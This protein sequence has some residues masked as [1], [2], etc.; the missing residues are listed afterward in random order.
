MYLSFFFTPKHFFIRKLSKVA[1]EYLFYVDLLFKTVFT[2]ILKTWMK[3][4]KKPLA[5]LNEKKTI[6]VFWYLLLNLLPN[7]FFHRPTKHFPIHKKLIVFRRWDS[8]TWATNPQ[9]ASSKLPTAQG[10]VS[11]SPETRNRWTRNLWRWRWGKTRRK[12][13]CSK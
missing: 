1:L 8:R 12:T 7:T 6:L 9:R 5:I 11:I 10:S 3:L 4:T 13:I 2:N